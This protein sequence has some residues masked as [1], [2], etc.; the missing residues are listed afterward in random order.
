L[1]PSLIPL[2]GETGVETIVVGI[3]E[4]DIDSA[5]SAL[6]KALKMTENGKD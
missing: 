4:F 6:D 1:R 5:A 2:I 3:D